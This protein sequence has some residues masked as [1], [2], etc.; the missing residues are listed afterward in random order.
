MAIILDQESKSDMVGMMDNLGM[1]KLFHDMGINVA[2]FPDFEVVS[3]HGVDESGYIFETGI[4]KVFG[5]C[6]F[7]I[8]DDNEEDDE[9]LERI[10]LLGTFKYKS[11]YA[12]V[13]PLNLAELNLDYLTAAIKICNKDEEHDHGKFV[14][15]QEQEKIYIYMDYM[16]GLSALTKRL[17][18]LQKI[19]TK[20]TEVAI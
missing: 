5:D 20:G 1:I 9:V 12:Y 19:L 13:I 17:I 8:S 6:T 18:L 3:R 15:D 10:K 2:K 14:G 7:L 11:E 16:G 4:S